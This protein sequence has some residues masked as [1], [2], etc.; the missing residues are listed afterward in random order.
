MRR[1]LRIGRRLRRGD[2]DR[3]RADVEHLEAAG[4]D[5]ASTARATW[6]EVIRR[7]ARSTWPKA[8]GELT[9]ELAAHFQLSAAWVA[10]E[11]ARLGIRP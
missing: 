3:A 10:G 5:F 8:V 7:R 6:N 1:W 9:A 4:F 11:L 2:A